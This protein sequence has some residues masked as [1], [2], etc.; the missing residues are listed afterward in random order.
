VEN[1]ED[2][3]VVQMH[4]GTGGAGTACQGLIQEEIQ[5]QDSGGS[6]RWCWWWRMMLLL[7]DVQ[8]VRNMWSKSAGAGGD[9]LDVIKYFSRITYYCCWWR[10]WWSC[11]I[12]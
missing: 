10:W 12:R 9:G 8:Q 1:Q 6:D 5:V 7:E 4:S 2:Q 11:W 3:V